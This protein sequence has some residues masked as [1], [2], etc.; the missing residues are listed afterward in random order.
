VETLRSTIELASR[1]FEAAGVAALVIGALVAVYSYV[2][3]ILA[4][5]GRDGY[6]SARR[7]LGRGILLALELLVAADIIRSVAI[8]PT[9]Q[10]VTV[11]GIIVLIRTFLSWSLEVEITGR[12]PWE[13]RPAAGSV[14]S[15]GDRDQA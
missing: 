12:W 7:Q 2:S 13:R 9:L 8:S 4:H 3:A 6:T 10:S 14:E 5:R 11:L 1:A 15:S